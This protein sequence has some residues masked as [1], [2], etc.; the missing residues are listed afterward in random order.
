M[1][2]IYLPF[3]LEKGLL[4]PAYQEF[5]KDWRE[6]AIQAAAN[7]DVASS[8]CH[9]A[10]LI[11][12]VL[13]GKIAHDWLGIMDEFLIDGDRPLAY[14]ELFGKRL[15]K[16]EAQAKQSTIHAIHTRW[17]IES[18]I[19]N[20]A[21]D[22]AKYSKLITLKKQSDGLFYDKDVSET[23]LRHRMKFELVM[24]MAMSCEILN[25]AGQLNESENI[26]DATNT[27]DPL[28]C[29][30]LGYMSM[31]YF[32]S[33]ALEV[34]SHEELFPVG[35]EGYIADCSKDLE[36][37]WCDFAMKYK[38]DAYMGTA[39]RV[40]RDRPIHSPLIACYV[41]HLL[42]YVSDESKKSETLK[43][44]HDYCGFLKGNPLSIPA[45][46]MRDVPIPFGLD[47]SPIEVICASYLINKVN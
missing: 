44:L 2:H 27:V 16:F 30:T 6:S 35:L 3:S 33:K 43:R 13:H 12:L 23:T 37:G 7:G 28:K 47:F 25:A 31:E 18:I 34:L 32:R 45:F 1:K 5:V 29:P 8:T 22:H 19:N 36:V 4:V 15:Y 21:A 14:S 41:E 26:K 10:S 39:K 40:Q 24:S 20:G 46:Q 9:Q 11:D 17:W 38:V 42:K